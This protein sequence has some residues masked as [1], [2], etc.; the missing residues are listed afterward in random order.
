M[1]WGPCSPI[2]RVCRTFRSVP[3]G[4]FAGRAHICVGSLRVLVLVD[5][6]DEVVLVPADP[7]NPPSRNEGRPRHGKVR[8]TAGLLGEARLRQATCV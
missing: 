1:P 4:D 6:Q 2:A 8:E 3:H 5:T 7:D